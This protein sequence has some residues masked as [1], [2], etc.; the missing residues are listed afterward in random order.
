[1][2]R[3]WTSRLDNLYCLVL[4][5][6]GLGDARIIEFEASGAHSALIMAGRHCRGRKAEV[7]ENGQS[8]CSI[9]SDAAEGFW[10]IMPPVAQVRDAA[11]G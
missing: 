2:G 6:D 7:F 11:I 4:G 8:L 10:V 5:K 3:E 1:M 9:T